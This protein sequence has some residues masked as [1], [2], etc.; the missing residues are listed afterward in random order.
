MKFHHPVMT[1][2]VSFF[3]QKLLETQK[4]PLTI[5]DWTL[6]HG[7]HVLNLFET[8]GKDIWTYVA[9]DLDSSM[10]TTA[11]ERLSTT[12][13]SEY[14]SHLKLYN[15]SYIN[16]ENISKELGKK[17]DVFF[18]DLGVNLWHFIQHE[19]GFSIKWDGILD[20]RYNQSSESISKKGKIVTAADVLNNYTEL[21]LI[22][23]FVLNSEISLGTSKKIAHEI[24][25]VRVKNPFETTTQ[26]NDLTKKLNYSARV[27]AIVFQ[28]VRIEINQEFQNIKQVMENCYKSMNSGG[29]L[30]ILSYHSGEDRIVKEYMKNMLALGQWTILTKHALS[31]TYKE[32]QGNKPSRS[33]KMRVFK[34]A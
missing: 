12:L 30:I 1:K 6:G 5:F 14:Q 29:I 21:Q 32:V 20:M 2:E 16:F 19:R 34:F 25:N 28:A 3:I 31:P 33:A 23:M 9:T 8:L 17:Y 13:A 18:L 11:Q 10:F 24:V 26:L 4:S 15:T 7:G 27:A 22:D